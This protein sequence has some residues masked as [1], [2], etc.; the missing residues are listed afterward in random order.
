MQIDTVVTTDLRRQD[1]SLKT[2]QAMTTDP[3]DVAGTVAPM[4][5][6]QATN[7]SEPLTDKETNL[8]KKDQKS[9]TE[10]INKTLE[11]INNFVPIANTNLVFEFD[12]ISD[13]PIIKVID[14]ETKELIREIPSQEIENVAKAFSEL[15]DKMNKSGLLLNMEA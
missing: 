5:A 7:L 3:K 15:A 2:A 10:S 1:L 4:A 9:V 8:D 12:D 6:A 11:K 13:P 14:K